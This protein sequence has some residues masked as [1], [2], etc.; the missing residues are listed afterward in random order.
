MRWTKT[1]TTSTS[2]AVRGCFVFRVRGCF[3]SSQ[4][5]CRSINTMRAAILHEDTKEGAPIHM[6]LSNLEMPRPQR[7]EVLIKNAAAGVCH[8]DLHIILG[9]I[10]FPKPAVCGHEIAGE[11]VELGEGVSSSSSA[12]ARPTGPLN[13]F[14]LEIFSYFFWLFHSSKECCE[15]FSLMKS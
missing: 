14:I 10:P 2:R 11:I 1:S 15:K 4:H 13:M 5:D 3:V 6:P 9:H 12:V 8:T 7:G